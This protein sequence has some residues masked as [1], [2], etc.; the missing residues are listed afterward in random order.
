VI[1]WKFALLTPSLAL[2][3]PLL[4]I[5]VKSAGGTGAPSIFIVLM[6]LV[7]TIRLMRFVQ[8][9]IENVGTV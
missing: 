3:N 2:L 8:N 9:C 1:V 7:G 6:A 5:A 4:P